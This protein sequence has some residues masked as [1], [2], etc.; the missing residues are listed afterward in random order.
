MLV[1]L[2]LVEQRYKAVLEVLD[3]ATSVTE[4][5]R[6]YE[7]SRQTIHKWLVRYASDGLAGLVDKSSKPETCPHQMPPV[8]E[9]KILEMRRAHPEW[10]PRTLLNRLAR[11]G[12]EP[13]PSMSA[14]YRC[15][16]RHTL[17]EPRPRKRRPSDYKAGSGPAPWSSGRW[18]SRSAC[19][20]P[21]GAGRRS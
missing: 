19:A 1:E 20:W 7:V 15:L 8:V 3:G 10:G 21:T 13:L 11:A 16:V 9:A 12:V 17:L 6:R 4:V 2:G 5:A 14:V 18:T